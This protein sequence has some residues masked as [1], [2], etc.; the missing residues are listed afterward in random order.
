MVKQANRLEKRL[1]PQP[2]TVEEKRQVKGQ[3]K[4]IFRLRNLLFIFPQNPWLFR[5]FGITLFVMLGASV[6]LLTPIWSG[7]DSLNQRQQFPWEGAKSQNNFWSNSFQYQLSRPLN[8]LILGFGTTETSSSVF[9]Q[10][11]N[12]ILLLRL[13]PTDNSVK[14]LSIPQDSQV[15][16]PGIGLAKVSLANARGGSA[17]A[18]R[19]ISR[20]LNN[21]PIDAYIRI[22]IDGLGELVDLL[23]GVEVFV[24]QR[25][26]ADQQ[27]DLALEP[28]WQTLNG[29]QAEQFARF[30]D[31]PVGDVARIQRQQALLQALYDRLSSPTV[32]PRLP[33]LSRAMLKYIDTNLTLEEVTTLVNFGV[34]NVEPQSFQ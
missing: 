10:P 2:A 17:L 4:K 15:V 28:G 7:R 9:N 23:G 29:E 3:K 24:P 22:N 12:T 30:S 6:A 16:I 34:T 5:G 19:A 13:D 33:D 31:S 1:E 8:I 21:V 26:S 14:V 20:A 18:A 27:P 25:I 32:L 11:S